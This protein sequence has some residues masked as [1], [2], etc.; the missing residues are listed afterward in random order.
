[1]YFTMFMLGFLYALFALFLMAAGMQLIFIGGIV[2]VMVVVQYY[3]S[4]R[5]ILMST[6]AKEVSAAEQPDLHRMVI[7]EVEKP[8][9]EAVM[10]HTGNNQSKASVMLG[11]NRGTLRTKLKS[12]GLL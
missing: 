1:M 5:L 2:G 12:Y 10:K 11:I 7:S 9:F 8:L 3:M 4:D 6:G